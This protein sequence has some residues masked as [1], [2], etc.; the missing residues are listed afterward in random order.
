M[1]QFV[2]KGLLLAGDV[3]LAE[4]VNGVRG[5]LVGPINFTEITVTPPTTEEKNRLSNK[6]SN[7]GQ[8]LDS[9]QLPKDPAKVGIKWDTMTKKLLADVV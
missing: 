3:Y 5:S 2:D 8:A 7:F 1:T 6:K 9:V 4:I